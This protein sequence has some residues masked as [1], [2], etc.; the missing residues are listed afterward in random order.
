MSKFNKEPEPQLVCPK[1]GEKLRTAHNTQIRQVEATEVRQKLWFCV[2]GHEY[3]R[4]DDLLA[5]FYDRS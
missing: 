5:D 2:A 3:W 1:C 4:A